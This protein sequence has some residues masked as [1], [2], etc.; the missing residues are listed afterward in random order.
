MLSKFLYI[1][2]VLGAIITLVYAVMVDSHFAIFAVPFVVSLAIVYIL[3]P[4]IDWWWYKRHPPQLPPTLRHLINTQLPFY[5]NLTVADKTRFR[6]RMAM[7]M[8]ANEFMPQGLESVPLDLMGAIAATAVQLTFGHEDYLMNKFEHIIVYPHPFPSPQHPEEWHACEHFE[9]DG[10][11]MFSAEQLMPGFMQPYRFLNIGLYEYSR[12]FRNCHP[13]VSFPAIGEEHWP[14]LEE[15]SG[16][17]KDK[18]IKY[19]GLKEIDM[20]ALAVSHFF[21]FGEK[22]KAVLPAEYEALAT[23]LKVTQE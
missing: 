9:E 8:E 4:Q 5:Q 12:V 23:A 15:I 6:T 22:F 3:S 2:F 7:Y 11:I 20:T 18:T 13:K 19:I 17:P 10:V 21:V 14:A 16:F 1:P